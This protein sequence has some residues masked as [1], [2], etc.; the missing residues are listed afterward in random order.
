MVEG[1]NERGL[2]D[3]SARKYCAPSCLEPN[4]VLGSESL[5]ILA[6]NY[7][8]DVNNRLVRYSGHVVGYSDQQLNC[9][10][11]LSYSNAVIHGTGH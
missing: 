6:Q 3:F 8:G 5:N 11:N 9:R 1:P 4:I 2:V 10:Q 7:S